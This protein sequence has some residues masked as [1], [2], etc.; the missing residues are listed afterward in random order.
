MSCFLPKKTH[1]WFRKPGQVGG[2][3]VRALLKDADF[4]DSQNWTTQGTPQKWV[5]S[6]TLLTCN[7]QS[8]EG[9]G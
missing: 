6:P 9:W 8:M 4:F 5:R 7:R 1:G 2:T 3:P